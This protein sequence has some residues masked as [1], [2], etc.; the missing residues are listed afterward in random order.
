MKEKE[1][2]TVAHHALVSELQQKEAGDSNCHQG[3]K[4]C[5][6]INSL[7]LSEP[8]QAGKE[9]L[10]VTTSPDR[11]HQGLKGLTGHRN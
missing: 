2:N 1:N 6:S 8:C 11:D 5:L 4:F 9:V 10:S 3:W 7:T